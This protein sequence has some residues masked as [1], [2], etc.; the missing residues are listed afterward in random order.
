MI[1]KKIIST[2]LLVNTFVVLQAQKL[3]SKIPNTA[4]VVIVANADNLFDLINVSDIDD[5]V[6]GTELLKNI[7]R[8]RGNKVNSVSKNGID[9]ASNAYYFFEKTDSISYHTFLVELNDRASYE[10]IFNERDLKKIKKDKGYSYIQKNSNIT[11]WNDEFLLF[12][13]GDKHN[14]YFKEH[15]ERFEK[16]KLAGQS[17]YDVKKMFSK[18]WILKK[19]FSIVNNRLLNSM[20]VNS[21]FQKGKKRN[22]VATFWIR[23]YGELMSGLIGSFGKELNSSMS[24]LMP[25]N[26]ENIYGVEEVTANLSFNKK[27]AS[28]LLDMTVS[29]DMK[30]SFKK[31]YNQKMNSTLINSFN[32]DKVLAFGSISIDTEQL[33]LEYPDMIDKMYSGMFP[34]FNEEIDVFGDVLSL[35]IDEKAIAKLVTGDALFVLNSFEKKEI[36]YKSYVYDAD[37][38]RK[39]VTKT[40]ETL[41]P[42]FTFM[43]GSEEK[44]LLT[45]LFKLGQKHH[46]VK[47]TNSVFEIIIKEAKL[48]FNLYAVIKNNVLYFTNSKARAVKISEGK[49]SFKGTKYRKLIKKNS[50]VLFLNVNDLIANLPN[51]SLGRTEK[52]MIAFSNDNIKDVRFVVSKMKGNKIS[53][54]LK[55]NTK[56]KKENTLK[57]LLEFINQIV[58]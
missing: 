5:S 14:N 22:A 36:N 12:I 6:L 37:Y 3:E 19:G 18:Q 58:K 21:S 17:I 45:K 50:N 24:Y 40:K 2:L 30:K 11:I 43:L 33:L 4:D 42:D 49:A 54:E 56:G 27:N 32:H 39:E 44:E 9:I 20:A 7:N 29:D 31:I 57:L 13:K 52:K 25:Q 55:L 34:E 26:G 47:G 10:S 46:L 53:S 38:K 41:V 23:N 15:K 8:K 48:P 28:L 1:I 35:I 51:E 16:L